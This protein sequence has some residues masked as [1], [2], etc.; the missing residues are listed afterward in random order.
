M[1]EQSDTRQGQ[2]HAVRFEKGK[3]IYK[4]L[5][6]SRLITLLILHYRF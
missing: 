6:S 4:N 1:P 2:G 3:A 5:L